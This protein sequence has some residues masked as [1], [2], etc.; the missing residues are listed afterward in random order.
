MVNFKFV[1]IHWQLCYVYRSGVIEF[2]AFTF[3]LKIRR[4]L[5]RTPIPLPVDR[6]RIGCYGN[7]LNTV[8]SQLQN[9]RDQFHEIITKAETRAFY[10]KAGNARQRYQ[11]WLNR[12]SVNRID[13]FSNT[14]LQLTIW[15][16]SATSCY[17]LKLLSY[18]ND[19]QKI[20]ETNGPFMYKFKSNIWTNLELTCPWKFQFDD[21]SFFLCRK[22]ALRSFLGCW[23][24]SVQLHWKRW[25]SFIQT[26]Y[27]IMS[28]K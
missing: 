17:A 11:S 4:V 19:F 9:E 12:L 10:Q 3:L 6:T 24:I 2:Y 28:T 21:A 25:P 23:A 13:G 15:S 26:S 8:L 14:S 1:F 20:W 7:Q 27:A 22:I 5:S 16:F 18:R